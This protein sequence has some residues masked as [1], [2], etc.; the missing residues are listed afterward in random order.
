MIS[1]GVCSNTATVQLAADYFHHN[2]EDVMQALVTAGAFRGDRRR[3]A[4][5]RSTKVCS[6]NLTTAPLLSFST[7]AHSCSKTQTSS[8]G[9]SIAVCKYFISRFAQHSGGICQAQNSGSDSLIESTV[10]GNASAKA[11]NKKQGPPL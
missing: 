8:A 7:I 11:E 2:D 3:S 5:H 6:K 4:S 9:R 1:R 10:C